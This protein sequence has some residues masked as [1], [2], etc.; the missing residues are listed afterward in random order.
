MKKFFYLFL[1]SMGLFSFQKIY[2]SLYSPVIK[3]LTPANG[4]TYMVT[5]AET[6][7]NIS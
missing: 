3:D 6:G 7:K 4:T 2:V 5:E 1:I